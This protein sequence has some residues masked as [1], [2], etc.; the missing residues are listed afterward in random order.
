M[1]NQTYNFWTVIDDS[2]AKKWLVECRC[3][4]RAI[5]CKGDVVSGK[6]RC[7]NACRYE[8]RKGAK[9]PKI[10]THGLSNSPTQTSWTEMKRRCLQPH[11]RG[12]ENYGGRG[13]T[14]CDRWLL[15]EGGKSGFHCFVDDMGERPDTDHQIDRIDNDGNYTPENCQWIHRNEQIYNRQNTKKFEV[16]GEVLTMQEACKK[17]S[18]PYN[19]LIS[20]LTTYK[21]PPEIAVTK[22]IS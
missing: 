9:S 11:R 18:I 16:F 22:P 2:V 14:V 5:R 10:T 17:Y 8:N 6:S 13:I 19:I 12:Y 7:C 1:L 15:G 21:M 4:F 20:R 3:G